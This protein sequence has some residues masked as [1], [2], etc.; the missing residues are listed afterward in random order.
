VIYK[1]TFFI[2]Y[3]YANFQSTGWSRDGSNNRSKS[4]TAET[5]NLLAALWTTWHNVLK[6]WL[7]E[8][9]LVLQTMDCRQHS[10]VLRAGKQHCES[11]A[12]NAT[13]LSAASDDAAQHQ[14]NWLVKYLLS[15]GLYRT[16]LVGL[17]D[18]AQW[19][20]ET[21]ASPCSL[22]LPA[23]Q[24][25][26][27]LKTCHHSQSKVLVMTPSNSKPKP[28]KQKTCQN[29]SMPDSMVH[30]WKSSPWKAAAGRLLGVMTILGSTARPCLHN[31]SKTTQNNK[32]TWYLPN[33]KTRSF[34]RNYV[35]RCSGIAFNEA[36]RRQRQ[37]DLWF[38][39]QPGL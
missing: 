21:R 30:D 37:E 2:T 28:T 39:D 3:M 34:L 24:R 16:N 14:Q 19:L 36:L 4:F 32:W 12:V 1:P 26:M 33:E 31:Q 7:P 18:I 22:S 9:L 23:A 25:V 35:P 13:M 6:C 29:K 10:P 27:G 11:A 38:W 20:S 15:R 5:H 17:G 8:W